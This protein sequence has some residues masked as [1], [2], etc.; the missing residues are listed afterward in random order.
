MK[1]ITIKSISP[2]HTDR[3]VFIGQTGSGKSTLARKL[4]RTRYNVW[5][6]DVNGLL[7]WH[8]PDSDY[9]EGEYLRVSSIDGLLKHQ[10]YPKIIFQPPV[11]SQDDF[12]L[13]DLFFKTA[14]LATGLTVYVDEAYA[15]T[16]KQV[17]PPYYKACLTRGRALEIETWTATQRPSNIPAYILSESEEIYL[18]KLRYPADLQRAQ[19]LTGIDE[20]YIRLLP[21][22][23]FC[24]VNDEGKI[25]YKLRLNIGASIQPEKQS[26]IAA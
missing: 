8:L 25:F 1:R 21:K 14:Y 10:A 24:F 20:D 13:F 4:L 23:Q 5:V 17:I 12:N 9:P 2:K 15:V 19:H 18:F 26:D 22:R 6:I 16:N 7:D 11:E 3:A